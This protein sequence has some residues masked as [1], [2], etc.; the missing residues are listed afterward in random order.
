MLTL[1]WDTNADCTVALLLH[2]IFDLGGYSARELVAHWSVYYPTN[3][4]RLAVIEALYQGRYK[5][6][7]VEQILGLWQRR[8]QVRQHFNCEFERLVCGNIQSRLTRQLNS[9]PTVNYPLVSQPLADKNYSDK[10]YSDRP[11]IKTSADTV[12][13]TPV[14]TVDITA[15][16]VSANNSPKTANCQNQHCQPSNH[17]QRSHIRG[18]LSAAPNSSTTQQPIRQF[19]P[20]T[21]KSSDFYT[22]LKAIAQ[23]H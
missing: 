10:N 20:T 21:T 23:H 22:K 18:I 1:A 11:Q 6:I 17:N 16:V 5:A 7:S 4:V 13:S 9:H 3:W 14:Q 15:K 8:G 12:R 19:N 2:Y